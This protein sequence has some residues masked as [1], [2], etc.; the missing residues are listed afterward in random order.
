MEKFAH[1]ETKKRNEESKREKD[2]W[3][4]EG[5]DS[6]VTRISTN[7]TVAHDEY[8]FSPETF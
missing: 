4:E 6:L 8:A 7:D 2:G 3:G 5:A 1:C